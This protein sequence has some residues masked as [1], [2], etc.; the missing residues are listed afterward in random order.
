MSCHGE[1]QGFNAHDLPRLYCLRRTQ[2]TMALLVPSAQHGIS[3]TNMSL[4]QAN[5]DTGGATSDSVNVKE[6]IETC[7]QEMWI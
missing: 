7:G 6:P 4:Q 1:S 2:R 3:Q 5:H